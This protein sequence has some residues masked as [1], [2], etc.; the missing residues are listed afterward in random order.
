VPFFDASND[1]TNFVISFTSNPRRDFG[2]F[3]RGYTLAANRLADCLLQAARFS[4]YEAYPVVFLYRHALELSLKHIIYSS[5]QLA[6]F[7]RLEDID[8]RL[9]NVHDLRAL[10]AV[11]QRLLARLFPDDES[12]CLITAEITETCREF[13]EIDPGS[14]SYRYPIGSKG[15]HSTKK[16][17]MVNLGSFVARMSSILAKLDSVHFGLEA[18]TDIAQDVYDALQHLLPSAADWKEDDA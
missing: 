16:H 18:E 10:A 14:D 2:V 6:A 4:D 13:S 17:Q 3:A 11:V 1:T 7:K 12:L 5:A 8:G 15:R 9:H